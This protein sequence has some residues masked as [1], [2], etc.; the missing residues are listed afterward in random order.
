MSLIP[1]KSTLKTAIG[2]PSSDLDPLSSQ[3][4]V[5]AGEAVM[6]KN[7]RR[8]NPVTSDGSRALKVAVK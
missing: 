6:L 5:G 3:L 2:F 8:H 4:P 1:K 7:Q